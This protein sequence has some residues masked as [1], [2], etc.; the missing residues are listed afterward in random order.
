MLPQIAGARFGEVDHV[1]AAF[2]FFTRE[3]LIDRHRV[4]ASEAL[5]TGNG[6]RP[7]APFVGAEH[8][9]LE[10]LARRGLDVLE[11]K[12]LLA[13]NC[14]KP[15][16]DLAT[17]SGRILE[18]FVLW[19]GVPLPLGSPTAALTRCPPQPGNLNGT[20]YPGQSP[21]VAVDR[22]EE[23]RA[24][25]GQGRTGHNG[26]GFGPQY[27]RPEADHR[28]TRAPLTLGP[29]ALGT[30]EKDGVRQRG[31]TAATVG[32][33]RSGTIGEVIEGG[34]RFH[35]GEPRPTALHR[36]FTRHR[37]QA[38]VVPR[39]LRRRPTARR[40]ARRRTARSGRRRPR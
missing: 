31:R 19:H 1:G 15:L 24:Q 7:L 35:G 3:Q 30:D 17:V 8:R 36:G 29:P 38:R 25:S 22:F 4:E 18:L 34:N 12:P 20:A 37:H 11:R 39:R 21:S 13:P 26:G 6:D 14:P 32:E 27:G 33:R 23:C 16:A 28:Q 9:R 2:A 10:L 5:E 40:I